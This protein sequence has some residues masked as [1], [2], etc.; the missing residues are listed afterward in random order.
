IPELVGQPS[1]DAESRLKG[2][3]LDIKGEHAGN[4]LD[5]FFG[6]QEQ[7]CELHPGGGEFVDPGSIVTVTIAPTC[8]SPE[9]S[10]TLSKGV[11]GGVISRLGLDQDDPWAAVVVD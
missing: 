1:D 9:L 2:L 8:P 5:R 3:G 4:F 6:G 10:D 11:G 7:V